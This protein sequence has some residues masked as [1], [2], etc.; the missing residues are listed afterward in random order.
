[1]AVRAPSNQSCKGFDGMGLVVLVRALDHDMERERRGS[2]VEEGD[3]C[4]LTRV[5]IKSTRW[6]NPDLLA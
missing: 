4:A 3:C 5:A 6:L 2:V 1:M